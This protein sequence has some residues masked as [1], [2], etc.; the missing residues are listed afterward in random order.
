MGPSITQ[1]TA[2]A[3][4]PSPG[5]TAAAAVVNSTLQEPAKADAPPLA[6]GSSGASEAS[7]D[8]A[9]LG[10]DGEEEEAPAR[11][12]IP[13]DHVQGYG[14]DDRD[15]N[16]PDKWIPRHPELI[17]LT[18]K[19]PFNC[20]PP[21]DR[22][23]DHGFI[24]PAS[25][26]YV[27]NHGYV[28]TGDWDTW[29]L[30]IG[31]LVSRPMSLSMAELVAMPSREVPVTLVCIGNRR[32]EQNMVKKTR[33]FNWGAAGL[34]TNTW[35]GVR[36]R[37][38]LL[39]CGILPASQGARFVCLEG[40]ETLPGKGGA[41]ST[42]GT[43]MPRHKAL[44]VTQDVI[45]AYEQNG[46]RL[47]PDHGFP[48]RIIIPGW[49]GGRM[50]KWLRRIEV[51]A[52]ES[53]N[54]YHFFDNRVLPPSVDAERADAEGWW[55]KPEYLCNE[56]SINSA[57]SAPM[58][59]E[60]LPLSGP[61]AQ[62]AAYLMKGYAYSGGGRKVLRV[63]VTLD[64]GATWRLCQLSHPE[65]PTEYGKWWCWCFWQLPVDVA[66][67]LGAKEIS[68]RA[69][70]EATNTQPENLIWNVLGMMNNCWFRIKIHPV[71][72]ASGLALRFEHPT[73]AGPAPG[74]WMDKEARDAMLAAP[75]A[76]TSNLQAPAARAL[77]PAAAAAAPAAVEVP[78][79]VAKVPTPGLKQISMAEVEAHSSPENPWIVV[80]GKVYDCTP[81]LKEHPGG[82]E[83]ITMNAGTD[84]TE[85]FDAIHSRKA[86]AMLADYLIG[87]LA[88]EA[89]IAAAAV[90]AATVVV[91]PPAA[92]PAPVSGTEL[93]AL[94]PKKRLPFP[95]I[96][97]DVL[98]PDVRRFRFGLPSAEHR[99]GL[100]V[101]KHI[102]LSAK[103]NGSLVMRAYTP[104]SSDEDRGHF[105][106]VVKVYFKGVHPNFP[107]G[108][109]LSQHLEGMAIGE[110]IDVKGPLGHLHWLG[111]GRFTAHGEQHAVTRVGMIAGGTG[112][113]PMYQVVKAA[114]R[115][116]QDRTQMWLVY[117]N[118]AVEDILL[119]EEL[120][121]WAREY[122]DRFRVWYTI[123]V[124]G[125]ENWAYSMG[126]VTKEMF[127]EHLPAAEE[128]TAIFMCGPPP[129]LKFGC[130]PNLTS[131]GFKEEQMFTF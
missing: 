23:V 6:S 26:H 54:Y 41:G 130:V 5:W 88:S 13:D 67:L 104:T 15:A 111:Q 61:G 25:L 107:D 69:W 90:A 59:N 131:I 124:A 22:L 64:D 68:V 94:D 24:T 38:V 109:L 20:E 89:A 105:D 123:E 116:P 32:K 121:A 79:A 66:D 1:D 14:I 87:E 16:T 128:G 106:L 27:R 56:L 125:P 12:A 42:Y 95:L 40:A 55:Y 85:E 46:Q 80:D 4:L 70:D 81:F 50:V 120:D 102:F 30:E 74:G 117:A 28:P 48:L 3:A 7:A 77:P 57:A 39:R 47:M 112:L 58:H 96:R 31:G 72:A 33:G 19:H 127:E 86:K 37:D 71:R 97:K 73:I 98:S 8:D 21:L 93:V 83:S 51:T 91:P 99:L 110:T 17:R 114:L 108:G 36:L 82:A 115:D 52:T 49:I 11:Y 10:A 29:R 35:R 60:E 34:S 122:P 100:P 119:R 65:R 62:D 92:A 126:R 43:S 113:T 75:A 101:G 84:C 129:M 118:R 44:D 78:A 2:D 53:Q 9:L 45:L 76:K 18:G 63:E 103:I